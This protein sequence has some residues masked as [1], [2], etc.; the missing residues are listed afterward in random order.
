[1]RTLVLNL[2]GCPAGWLGPYGNEWVVTPHLDRLAS[3]SIVFDRHISDCPEADAARRA[4]MGGN[5]TL[6]QRLRERGI[7]AIL[8][9][10]NHSERDAPDWYYAGWEQVF[11]ARPREDDQSP[12][13]ALVRSLP[14]LLEQLGSRPDYLL[15]IE[16]DRL[17][18]PWTISQEVFDAYLKHELDDESPEVEEPDADE[19]DPEENPLEPAAQVEKPIEPWE[20]LPT[21]PFDA[22]DLAAVE[23]LATSFGSV[24]TM[25]DTELGS[26]FDRFRA[27]GLDQS[28]TWIVTS[29]FGYPLGEHGQIG[30]HRP[31]LHE[32][33]VHVP[34]MIRLAGGALAGSRVRALTQPSDVPAAI[35]ELFSVQQ[36]DSRTLLGLA[37]GE[38]E[39]L[40]THAISRLDLGVAAEMAIRTDDW[41]YLLPIR[42]PEGETREPKLYQKPDDR[43]EVNDLKARNIGIADELE[44]ILKTE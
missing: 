11:D 24:V 40:R 4:W 43:W 21:G 10:A 36:S 3:E 27:R 15:W 31:W 17:L 30:V 14:S 9:R 7:P 19:V 13:D 22:G 38:I 8:V 39:E 41:A 33:L 12:L 2:R 18:P 44:A 34:L 25:L 6:V 5:P 1:M 29:D 26:L 16:I 32:E 35:L 23:W 28:A 37:R 42:L 20:D